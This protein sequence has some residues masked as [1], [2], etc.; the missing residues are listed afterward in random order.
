MRLGGCQCGAVRYWLDQEPVVV[1]ACHCLECR[2]QSA[3]AFGLSMSI[4]PESLRVEGRLEAYER[5]TD[6]GS[7]TRCWF[8][9]RCGTRIFHQP[10]RAGAAA[11]LKGGTL[12]D[13]AEV[14]PV[15]HIWVSR[16][17]PWVLL[18]PAVPAFDS[19]PENFAA[20]RD[21]LIAEA[22]A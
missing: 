18:D 14:Q 3:S 9:P 2:K 21:G 4:R 1:Y 16:K 8:C 12:D 17:L 20:W 15:A 10:S 5:P 6:S 7:V 22:R 11:S 13:I 19:Q